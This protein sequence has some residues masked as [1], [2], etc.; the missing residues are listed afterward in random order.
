MW[1]VWDR[2]GQ[3]FGY[4]RLELDELVGRVDSKVWVE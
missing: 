2:S 4:G 3:A 1:M